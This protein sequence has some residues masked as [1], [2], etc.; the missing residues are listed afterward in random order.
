L[1]CAY[2]FFGEDRLLFG[3]DMPYDVQQG[4]LSINQTIEAIEGMDIPEASKRK[5]YEGNARNLLHL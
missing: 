1:M 2:H 3:S 5:I 4:A